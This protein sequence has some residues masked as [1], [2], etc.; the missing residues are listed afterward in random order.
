MKMENKLYTFWRLLNDHSIK[1]PIIQRDYAQ[2]RRTEKVDF[3]RKEFLSKL[4]AA[5][6]GNSDPLT[7]DFIYGSIENNAFLPLD[8][9]QRLTALFLL[10]W[11]L[12]MRE[13]KL[14]EAKE[15]LIKFTYETRVSSRIFCN[16]L[17]TKGITELPNN[18]DNVSDIIKDCSWFLLSWKKDPTVQ[19][20]L[21]VL[22]DIHVY[23]KDELPGM[24]DKLIDDSKCP[25][26]FQFIPLTNFGLT[27]SL[28][29]K[30]NA[31]GK[32]LTEFENL[33]ARLELFIDKNHNGLH[34]EFSEKMD[35]LWTDL[36]WPFKD[37]EKWLIDI[38]FVRF[39]N[40]ITELCYYQ[41]SLF[42]GSRFPISA[43]GENQIDFSLIPKIYS[44]KENIL[45]LINSLDL[46]ASAGDL[47]TFFKDVFA[48]TDYANGKVVLF[49]KNINLFSR[50]A[51][52]TGF[53]INE[54]LLLYAVIL[55]KLKNG[56]EPNET[57]Q[58]KVRLVR[59]LLSRIR[60]R[61]K[62]SIQPELRYEDMASYMKD[63]KL[64]AELSGEV[65]SQV[66]KK[67]ALSAFK[68]YI[69]D[70]EEKAILILEDATR[71]PVLQKLEDHRFLRGIISNLGI[72]TNKDNLSEICNA[73]YEIWDKQID[74]KG[75]NLII[76]ALLSHGDIG[77]EIGGSQMGARY[78][79]GNKDNWYTTLTYFQDNIKTTL[80]AFIANYISRGQG[81][82]VQKL[83]AIIKDYLQNDV[84]KDWRYYFIKYESIVDSNCIYTWANDFEVQKLFGSTLS[85][86]HINPYVEAVALGIGNSTICSVDNCYGQ[87]VV[88]TPLRLKHN[89]NIYSKEKGWLLDLTYSN[90]TVPD[91]IIS[92]FLLTQSG[93]NY[94]LTV[95]DQDR[96]EMVVEL[97]RKLYPQK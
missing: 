91:N 24:Y 73:I 71:K 43:S 90:L 70:E 81:T 68:T 50:C 20:M 40:Y 16:N 76:R 11:Y 5:V 37:K 1:I 88:L 3:I 77:I 44:S 27:D 66:N 33:K 35:G 48:E 14:E 67:M 8:G 30:M 83:N 34:K 18:T 38:P 55:A 74:E 62:T 26:N 87:T 12:A 95:H 46:F 58:D 23:F 75:S 52:A 64:I 21:V 69:N 97:T 86:E 22:D 80:S 10:H 51:L 96:I 19:S 57:F 82:C 47:D 39:F 65:Y 45:F 61:K 25:I 9:Q 92:E 49:Q 42:V 78:Y 53:G 32:L 17:V 28:Y 36:F 6:I 2:G 41:N 89:L 15:V 63:V 56:T 4:C 93:K 13:G 79:F 60:Q 72:T 7:F 84:P 59:N 85:S 29:I 31:R 94:F 54:K